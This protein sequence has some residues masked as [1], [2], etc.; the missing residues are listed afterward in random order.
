[1]Q[2]HD[3]FYSF[4][5]PTPTNSDTVTV[6]FSGDVARMIGLDPAECDRPEFAAVFSGNA[7]LPGGPRPYAQCYG[8]HQFG[9]VRHTLELE[10]SITASFYEALRG[11]RK[12]L[13][14]PHPRV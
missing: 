2:V 8:G 7:P 11:H 6:A 3:A 12:L 9:M 5:A 10:N 13:A 1:M 14:A 4:V